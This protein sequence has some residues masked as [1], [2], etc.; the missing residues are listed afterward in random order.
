MTSVRDSGVDNFKKIKFWQKK[1]LWDNKWVV[2]LVSIRV[3]QVFK[4][5]VSTAY[6]EL[7]IGNLRESLPLSAK[8]FREPVFHFSRKGLDLQKHWKPSSL[9]SHIPEKNPEVWISI[10]RATKS[11]QQWYLLLHCSVHKCKSTQGSKLCCLNHLNWII[12]VSL[13]GVLKYSFRQ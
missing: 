10:Q 11:E 13:Q 6:P 9:T 3:T 4:I 8:E 12:I 1:S 2:N 5:P 7:Y